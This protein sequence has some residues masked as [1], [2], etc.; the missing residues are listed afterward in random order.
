PSYL[1]LE[2]ERERQERG[3]GRVAPG[4]ARTP[5]PHQRDRHVVCEFEENLPTNPARTPEA[6]TSSHHRATNRVSL[7]CRHHL[8]DGI[9][10]CAERRAVGSVFDVAASEH[11][12]RR[13]LDGRP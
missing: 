2:S 10:L 12:S 5:K 9:P 3:Q 4:H 8:S 6:L 1:L 7:S 13:T 11:G